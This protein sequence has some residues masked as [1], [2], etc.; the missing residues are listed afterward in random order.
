MDPA[1]LSLNAGSSSLKFALYQREASLLHGKIDRIGQEKTQLIVSH[2]TD[3]APEQKAIMAPNHRAA[4]QALLNWLEEQ[5]IFHSVVAVAHRI[6]H[7]KNHTQPQRITQKLLEELH[8]L[9]S[10][11]PNHLPQE[12][13]LI[14]AVQGRYPELQQVACF[15]TA[16][17]RTLPR[18]A[19]QFPI[20]R[21]Y[22]EQG[23][24]RYG[25][26]GLSY[27]Y[28]MEEL[29][30]LA[31]SQAAQGRII[32][33]HLGNGASLAAVHGGKSLDTTMGFTPTAG[34]MMGSRSGDLDPGV[35][36]YLAK[37][38]QMS[39]EEF[40]T[41]VNQKSG[42]LGI[43]ETSS[44]MHTLLAKEKTDP[45]AAEAIE[46]FCYYAKKGI[47][48]YAAVQGGV[49]TLVFSGG[50]GENAPVVRA[51]ICEGL[52]FL[53][54]ELEDCA[55]K[56]SAPIISSSKSRVVVRVI[57]TNEEFMMARSAARV[58]KL[59]LFD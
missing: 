38:E 58:L 34:L 16:F 24:E 15:D 41:M 1:I 39:S 19:K 23:I 9:E 22:G 21:R 59:S 13:Q 50:I 55:N 37:T 46:L 25:F 3:A 51:R 48:A 10:Y 20:P 17:H 18:V 47:G 36:A 14:K 4:I 56:E 5:D 57:P 2:E 26:H 8:T 29:T 42:L 54:I 40:Y 31:G 30:R 28:L 11:A 52:A 32:L 7:G 6:V 27:E 45:R 33:A 49:E 35:A 43:S 53:G 44:N 12:L